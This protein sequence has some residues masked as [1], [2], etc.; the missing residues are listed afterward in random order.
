[1]SGRP[2]SAASL[3]GNHLISVEH[4]TVAVPDLREA[5]RFYIQVLGFEGTRLRRREGSPNASAILRAGP[6]KVVLLEGSPESAISR[7]IAECGPGLHH[8]GLGVNDL[9]G[10][11]RD[12]QVAGMEFEAPVM[13]WQGCQTLFTSRDPCSG[14]RFEFIERYGGAPSGVGRS[15]NLERGPWPSVAAPSRRA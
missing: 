11:A 7:F 3:L 8:L 6:L 4:L 2:Q 1:M 14:L 13:S 12:L 10:L 9:R 5:V 15:T